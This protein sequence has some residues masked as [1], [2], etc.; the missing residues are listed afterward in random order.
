MDIELQE[1]TGVNF[2][3]RPQRLFA[4]FDSNR[5][6]IVK[7]KLCLLMLL[8][9][10]TIQA[11][12][13]W[14]Y[15]TFTDRTTNTNYYSNPIQAEVGNDLQG[16]WDGKLYGLLVNGFVGYV[17]SNYTVGDVTGP[18]CFT[19]ATAPYNTAD[20]VGVFLS[21]A[22]LNHSGPNVITNFTN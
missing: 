21:S 15:C 3:A 22:E 8:V 20:A 18:M 4:N 13:T 6:H 10:G 12:P 7:K 19:P 2:P 1:L 17:Q 16:S 11:Q 5:G 14:T 9:A